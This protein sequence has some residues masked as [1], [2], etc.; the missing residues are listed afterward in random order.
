VNRRRYLGA[1]GTAVATCLAGCSGGGDGDASE[2]A[3]ATDEST[4]V[5]STETRTGTES[6]AVGGTV[7]NDATAEPTSSAGLPDDPGS[8]VGTPA[9]TFTPSG[10]STPMAA[11]QFTDAYTERLREKELRTGWTTNTLADEGV[12]EIAYVADEETQ[13]ARLQ[14]FTDAFV[15]VVAATGGTGWTM[16]YEVQ[17]SGGEVWY[18]WSLSDELAIEYLSGERSEAAFYE[19]VRASIDEQ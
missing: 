14:A 10:S 3:V 5:A 16:R 7:T 13:E 1:V 12:V 15:E 19:A 6:T 4:V 18:T 2:T 8:E 11:N 9:E 17:V